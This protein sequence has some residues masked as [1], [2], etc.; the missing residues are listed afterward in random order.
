MNDMGERQV[1]ISRLENE[2]V[3]DRMQAWLAQHPGVL[4][5][6]VAMRWNIRL[7]RSSSG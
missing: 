6:R 3:L 7:A 2:A 4:D 1:V 5:R